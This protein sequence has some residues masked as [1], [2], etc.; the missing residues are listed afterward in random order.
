MRRGDRSLKERTGSSQ[1]AIAKFIEDKRKAQLPPNFKKILS[2]QLRKLTA[3]VSSHQTKHLKTQ[4]S[5]SSPRA[6]RSPPPRPPSLKL[7]AAAGKPSLRSQ[8]ASAKTKAT[9]VKSAVKKAAKPKSRP[10]AERRAVPAKKAAAAAERKAAAMPAK[11]KVK[12]VKK[13]AAKSPAKKAPAAKKAK[14]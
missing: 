4:D 6:R 13:A 14:K 10:S 5:Y 11:P 3:G 9:K 12:S 8:A 1:Y 2:F 7:A